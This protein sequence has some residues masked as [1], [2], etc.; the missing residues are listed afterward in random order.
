MKP[1]D[2]YLKFVRWSDEDQLYIGY[3]PDLFR[4]GVCHSKS[5][6]EAYAELSEIVAEEVESHETSKEPLP[7]VVTHVAPEL[8]FA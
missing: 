2:Q 3:C 6:V 1:K 8:E 5:E 7:E 4:G